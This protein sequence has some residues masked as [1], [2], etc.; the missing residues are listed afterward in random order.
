MWD[1]DATGV[2]YTF[3]NHCG[4]D[5]QVAAVG[6]DEQMALSNGE[7]LAVV[8]FDQEPDQAFVVSRSDGTDGVQVSPGTTTIDIEGDHCP[9]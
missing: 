9:T 8:T 2:T 4:E 7:T 3:V 1:D 5:V 6:D